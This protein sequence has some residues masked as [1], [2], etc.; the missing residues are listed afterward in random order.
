MS[1]K[2]VGFGS[3]NHAGIHPEIAAAMQAANSGHTHSYGDDP[4]TQEALDHCRR[5]FGEDSQTFFVF[6][7]TAANVLSIAALTRSY[8]AVICARTSHLN[9]DEST[10][11][12]HFTGCRLLPLYTPD[13][14]LRPDDVKAQASSIGNPHHAQPRLVSI[15]QSTEVGTVYTPEEIAALAECAHGLG[16]YLHMDGARLANAAAS[17]GLELRQISTDVGVDMLSFGGT[18]NGMML[19]EAVV[20]LR[21]ELAGE[22]GYIRKQGLQLA[23][24]MRFLSV[25]FTALLQDDLWRRNAEHANKMARLLSQEAAKVPGV[26]LSQKTQ[27]NAVFA[28]IPK[29]CIAALQQEFFFYVWDEAEGEVRWMCAYDTREEDVH[30]FVATMRRTLKADSA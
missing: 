1:Q 4:Y 23:S 16:L 30:S 19:G 13:G 12:E 15:T 26:R 14:K 2:P 9:I 25:Q 28:I 29:E 6:N 22:F 3:D 8:H 5:H 24:K 11:P 21:S 17:L 7:G 10:A 18:K 27:A 20:V